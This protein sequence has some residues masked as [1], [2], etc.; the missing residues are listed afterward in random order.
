MYTN[1]I[2]DPPSEFTHA[3]IEFEQNYELF[4]NFNHSR[5][6]FVIMRQQIDTAFQNADTEESIAISARRFS[7]RLS[8]VLASIKTK[9]ESNSC[10]WTIK[11]VNFVQ[12]IYPLARLTLDMTSSLSQATPFS[13]PL[14]VLVDGLGVILQV[15]THTA[16]ADR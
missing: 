11:L 12:K 5:S 9:Q 6:Q 10:K 16:V 13:I 14:K 8:K 1:T 7:T 4:I 2:L 15:M 3:L